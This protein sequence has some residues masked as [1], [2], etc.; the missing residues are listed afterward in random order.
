[1]FAMIACS[2]SS[3]ST[4][5]DYS[6]HPLNGVWDV[7]ITN[8]DTEG[9]KETTTG[10]PYEYTYKIT[11]DKIVVTLGIEAGEPSTFTASGD[12]FQFAGPNGY[13]GKMLGNDA[14]EYS[15]DLAY[16]VLGL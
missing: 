12:N 14:F 10:G 2:D 4:S 1:M 8:I 5:E 16:S 9:A 6:N 7:M 13:K 11:G 15:I 3:T